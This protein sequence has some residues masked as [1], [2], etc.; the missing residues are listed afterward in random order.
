[1]GSKITKVMA[2][3]VKNETADYFKDKPLN[4]VVENVHTLAENNEIEIK[5]NGDVVINGE[6]TWK[7]CTR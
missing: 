2:I 1:M 4:K 5:C 3:R 6:E 7:Q